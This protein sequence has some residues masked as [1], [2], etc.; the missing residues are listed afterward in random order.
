MELKRSRKEK[1]PSVGRQKI[2]I[3][4]IEIKNYLYVTFLKCQSGLFKKASEL[5]SLCGVEAASIIFSFGHPDVEVMVDRF[6]T[7]DSPPNFTFRASPDLLEAHHDASIR[8]LNSHLTR[9]QNELEA[10]RKT[11][12]SLTKLRKASQSCC[13]W[14]APIDKL[15]LLK[16]KQLRDSMEELKKNVTNQTD[17]FLVK[18]RNVSS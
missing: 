13:W 12:E 4:K 3:V 5:C 15:G 14:E 18:A 9:L 16:L 2:K 6:I 10:K 1:K 17:K 8:G 7:R 11:G